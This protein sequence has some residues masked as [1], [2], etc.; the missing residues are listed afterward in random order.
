MVNWRLGHRFCRDF[1]VRVNSGH[2]LAEAC[3]L[4]VM[5]NRLATQAIA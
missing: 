2:D 3:G 4:I 1:S 5:A